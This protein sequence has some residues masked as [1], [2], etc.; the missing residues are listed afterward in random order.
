MKVKERPKNCSRLKETK[1][2][3]QLNTMHNTDWEPVAMENIIR[4]IGGTEEG[5]V[6]IV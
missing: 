2:T 5:V 6:V 3:W 4:T 1:V